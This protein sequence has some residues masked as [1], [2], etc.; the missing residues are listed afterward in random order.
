MFDSG[1]GAISIRSAPVAADLLC[2]GFCP[3]LQQVSC[4]FLIIWKPSYAPELRYL[5]QMSPF[6]GC[7]RVPRMSGTGPAHYAD[8]P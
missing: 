2:I 8:I 4:C 7:V 5:N 1:E 3:Y 6:F